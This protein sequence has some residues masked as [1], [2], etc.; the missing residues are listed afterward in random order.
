MALS[1]SARHSVLVFSGTL[2]SRILGFIRV[3][4]FGTTLGYSRLSDSYSLANGT[5]NMMYE[6]I[7]GSLI[8]S[9]MVPFF[10]QQHKR[11]DKDADNALMSFVLVS[12][13]SLTLFC[14][15]ISP[16]LAKFLT[17]LN[18]SENANAQNS[19]VLFFMLFFLP[20][21][22]FYAMTAAM[23]A[24]LAARSKFT[25]AAFAP[26]VN[27]IV[28][29]SVLLYIRS[30]SEELDV[31]LDKVSSQPLVVIFALGTTLGIISITATLFISYWKAGGRFKFVSFRNPHIRSLAS[32][33]K[34]MVGYA[35]A[36][37]ITLFVVIAFA[38]SYEGGV[39]MNLVALSFFQLPYGLIAVTV[40][41][42]M[43]PRISRTLNVDDKHTKIVENTTE[44]EVVSRQT[45]PGLT[46][47]MGAVSAISV[48]IAIPSIVLLISH[49]NISVSEGEHTGRVLI[50]YLI[51]LPAFSLYF[52][53]V[54]LANAFN[55]T[56][57]VFYINV[58]QN[59]LNILI[60][61]FMRNY[62][63]TVGLAIAFSASY[64]IIIWFSIGMINRNLETSLL[65][66]GV[67]IK[68][69][70]TCLISG[71]VGY[72]ASNQFTG[73]FTQIAIG[74]SSCLFILLIGAFFAKK[75]LKVLLGLLY[76][77]SPKSVTS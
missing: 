76:E 57:L 27:N 12:A 55:K 7:L 42:T 73:E 1:T 50:A 51:S 77:R 48:A 11:K 3:I 45:A 34:W 61:I 63:T 9:T 33:S 24:Y 39:V 31:P 46:I 25:A 22:F 53:C 58:G 36:N 70:I 64:L 49:G 30:R 26:I 21:I 43:I 2:T 74:L 5:P 29:I 18:S 14:L 15:A 20:Q 23:Q 54:R 72:L 52:F 59:A 56:K 37:Q 28:V 41:T 69:L 4:I 35:I 16:L 65:E 10:V 19:L 67:T 68:M 44:T 66:K 71:A 40:M 75:D 17:S 60:A 32:S 62:L 13:L 8:A 38:N 6:L 47:I